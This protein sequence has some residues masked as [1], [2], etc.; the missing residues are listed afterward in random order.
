MPEIS[1]ES[2]VIFFT[3]SFSE[4]RSAVSETTCV[5]LFQT[6]TVDLLKMVAVLLKGLHH[7][8]V[9]LIISFSIL[10]TIRKSPGAFF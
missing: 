10:T 7:T 3:H 5:S 2:P 6:G 4:G 8:D 1:A 9:I